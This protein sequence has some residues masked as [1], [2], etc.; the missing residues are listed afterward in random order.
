MLDDAQQRAVAG[1]YRI[2]TSFIA[3]FR[4][5][6]FLTGWISNQRVLHK[7]DT[8]ATAI[9]AEAEVVK[10]SRTTWSR[11]PDGV[12]LPWVREFLAMQNPR[13][14][15]VVHTVGSHWR[16]F[17]RY[18]AEH[19]RFRPDCRWQNPTSCSHEELVNG[20][21]NSILYADG[22]LSETIDL[23]ADVNAVLLYT[24]DHGESLGESGR[25]GHGH[26]GH[27]PEQASVPLIAWA[28][29]EFR[30]RH[31]ERYQALEDDVTSPLSHEVIFH[32]MLDCAGF[33]SD[34]MEPSLSLCRARARERVAGSAQQD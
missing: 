7:N 6:G 13:K 34:V 3:M 11:A 17:N 30:R 23:L 18:D 16:Y 5:A 19:A 1:V 25:F 21:D 4:G 31:P 2:E 12:L 26:R 33:A 29:P 28:S 9:A 20:Y 8:A 24:S 22:F 10:Y 15:L 32:T 14:L 27:A